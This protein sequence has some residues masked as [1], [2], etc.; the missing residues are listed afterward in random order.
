MIRFWG[1]DIKKTPDECVHVIEE[2]IFDLQ[3]Q[4]HILDQE[5]E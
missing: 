1:K 3:M 2:T 4:N 5:I